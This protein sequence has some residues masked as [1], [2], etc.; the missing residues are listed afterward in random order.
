MVC[1]RVTS[2]MYSKNA[3]CMNQ[4][5][6]CPRSL[7]TAIACVEGK[8]DGGSHGAL[9][10]GSQSVGDHGAE[11]VGAQPALQRCVRGRGR[12]G[13]EGHGQGARLQLR[14]TCIHVR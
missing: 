2:I 6:C 11:S 5:S 3:A 13:W 10:G 14:H 9:V 1:R 4:A 8:W 7:H 12:R